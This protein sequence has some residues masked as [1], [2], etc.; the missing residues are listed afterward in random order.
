[1]KAILVMVAFAVGYAAVVHRL[2]ILQIRDHERYREMAE[3]QQMRTVEIVPKRGTIY[4]TKMQELAIS[5]DAV[6]IYAIPPEIQDKTGTAKALSRMTGKSR[7]KI[8]KCLLK[9][10]Q[11]V[12]IARKLDPKVLKKLEKADFEGVEFLYESKRY[13]PNR[14]LAAGLLGFVGLDN[15]GLEGLEYEYDDY[16]KGEPGWF[17]ASVDARA[18]KIMFE[19]K[20]YVKPSGANHLVL[21]IDKTI[22]YI[23]ES[24]LKRAVNENQAESGIAVMM[25]PGTGEILSM[26]SYPGF[27]PNEF[28]AYRPL[29]RQ[30]RAILENFEPGSTFKMVTLSSA[31]DRGV[32]KKD[33]IFFCENGSYLF[34]SKVYHDTHEYGWLSPQ[35][36]LQR[37]SNIGAIKI[38]ERLKDKD[39]F[40]TIKDFGFGEKTGVDLPGESK[41]RVRPVSKWSGIS[42]ASI[43]M[44]HEISVTA[45][46]VLAGAAAIA[47]QGIRN[48]PY[49]V[50][51]VI[52]PEG[53]VVLENRPGMVKRVISRETA[54]YITRSMESVVSEKGTAPLAMVTG[55]RVAGKTGTAQKFDSEAGRYSKSKYVSS[56]VGFVPAEEPE[57]ALI[58][59]LNEP[60]G[61]LYYGGTVAAPSFRRIAE[62]TL[63]YLRVTPSQSPKATMSLMEGETTSLSKIRG[64]G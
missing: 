23:T 31:F 2:Y 32:V 7:R 6:S 20:G 11:F 48:Q 16:V 14:F 19:G 35:Q 1:M 45:L 15:K 54:E 18:R 60:R 59:V 27:N 55:F 58:V 25:R 40:R 30:N 62:R 49:V 43:S 10:K 29:D 57:I 21:T 28:Q 17:L 56:F 61:L 4:D 22:Q 52:T 12:W 13:Y 41:G 39:F 26:A 33:D 36:I 53:K 51:R 9:K 50:S 34:R 5:V 44:G 38:S 63:R 64:S 46:Q 8:L 47:N 3:K 42:R 24:E 37:S